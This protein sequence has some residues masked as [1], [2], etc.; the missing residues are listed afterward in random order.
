MTA[1]VEQFRNGWRVVGK[2]GRQLSLI[3]AWTSNVSF[4]VRRCLARWWHD[5]DL[6]W[7]IR[8]YNLIRPRDLL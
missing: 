8:I 4:V 2:I 1:K 6:T 3:A 7:R 5:D